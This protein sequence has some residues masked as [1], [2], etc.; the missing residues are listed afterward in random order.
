MDHV[1]PL[2]SDDDQM[3][4]EFAKKYL[5]DLQIYDI[6]DAFISIEQMGVR[7]LLYLITSIL[8]KYEDTVGSKARIENDTYYMDV[9]EIFKSGMNIEGSEFLDFCLSKLKVDSKD[10]E[11]IVIPARQFPILLTGILK[12]YD[13]YLERK[14]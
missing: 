9:D 1:I 13:K 14:K 5:N 7:S 6:D 2:L 4:F 3:K 8:I 11:D 10:E 12:D